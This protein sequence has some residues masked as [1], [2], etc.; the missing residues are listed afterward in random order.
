MAS[1]V[2]SVLVSMLIDDMLKNDGGQEVT[3][4]MLGVIKGNWQQEI[5]QKWGR[6]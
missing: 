1:L 3:K 5:L 6:H 2:G 4:L